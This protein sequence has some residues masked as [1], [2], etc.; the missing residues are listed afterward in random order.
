MLNSD[1]AGAAAASAP[2][3]LGERRLDLA[4]CCLAIGIN[5]CDFAR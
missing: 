5:A 3:R 4:V 1:L 2:E